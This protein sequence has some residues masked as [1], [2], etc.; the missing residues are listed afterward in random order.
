[1]KKFKKQAEDEIKA[2]AELGKFLC[3]I[4]N[5]SPLT[6]ALLVREIVSFQ[7]VLREAWDIRGIESLNSFNIS[8]EYLYLHKIQMQVESGEW[9]R[10]GHGGF[11]SLSADSN[12]RLETDG[13]FFEAN[14]QT[15]F[16]LSAS[17]VLMQKGEHAIWVI[18][19]QV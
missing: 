3:N 13:A 18:N 6:K 9:V 2:L 14:G 15:E 16:L 17:P 7:E 19:Y 4:Q 1:M 10:V 11:K 8:N 12:I 5:I